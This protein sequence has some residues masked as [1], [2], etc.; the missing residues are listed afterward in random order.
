[1]KRWWRGLGRLGG[2]V[3]LGGLACA[4]LL[5]ACAPLP[6]SDAR[7]PERS[8]ENVATGLVVPATVS[9]PHQ[10]PIER[11]PFVLGVSSV[12]VERMALRAAC[13]GGPGAG[14]LTPPG[15]VEVYR[16]TCDDGKTFMARC[17]LRQCTPM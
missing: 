2:L 9:V 6:A 3:G 4:L 15:P 13:T 14:R 17:E 16:M 10:T 1:M 11:V 12:T 5:A 8:V 7:A